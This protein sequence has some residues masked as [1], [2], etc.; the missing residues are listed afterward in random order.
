MLATFR[1]DG[2]PIS[3]HL[4]QDFSHEFAGFPFPSIP[5]SILCRRL[6]FQHFSTMDRRYDRLVTFVS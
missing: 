3:V 5:T 6:N 1:T 2:G 4:C